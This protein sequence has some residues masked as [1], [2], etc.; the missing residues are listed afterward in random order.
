MKQLRKT[1]PKINQSAG[2]QLEIKQNTENTDDF[3]NGNTNK[4]MGTS[5]NVIFL[6]N[7]LDS[8]LFSHFF[9]VTVLEF[10]LLLGIF[11]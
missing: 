11:Y 10:P 8:G 1:M 4:I 5:K 6:C 3:E 7:F 2:G 9:L